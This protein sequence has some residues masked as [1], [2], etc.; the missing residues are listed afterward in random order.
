MNAPFDSF[1]SAALAL[2]NAGVELRQREGQ[3]LGGV[4]FFEYEALSAK[5][6]KWLGILLERH[7]LP[8]LEGGEG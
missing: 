3:F 6:A 8:P 5:Q 7:G 2:L 4:A 1:R